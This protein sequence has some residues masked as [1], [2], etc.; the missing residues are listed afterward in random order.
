MTGNLLL[1]IRIIF[2]LLVNFYIL[3]LVDS[4]YYYSSYRTLV[5]MRLTCLAFVGLGY[6][7]N[8][9][10]IPG[11]KVLSSLLATGVLGSNN[12]YESLPLVG[13]NLYW[14]F[15]SE[16][17]SF[18]L[19]TQVESVIV[20]IFFI[21]FLM[22][23]FSQ[24]RIILSPITIYA[25]VF[26]FNCFGGFSKPRHETPW[27]ETIIYNYFAS[28]QLYFLIKYTLLSMIL[29]FVTLPSLQE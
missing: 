21:A 16:D 29:T 9:Y 23:Y 13:R 18:E 14:Y 27:N 24:E 20:F 12:L 28:D 1:G 25:I 8:P 5:K 4:Y 10:Q 2:T 3:F 6:L 11:I 17:K 19:A 15:Y 7:L 26:F 22:I